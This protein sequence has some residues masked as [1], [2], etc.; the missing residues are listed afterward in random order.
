[1]CPK[2]QKSASCVDNCSNPCQ[3]PLEAASRRDSPPF[4]MSWMRA[5]SVEEPSRATAQMP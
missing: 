1:M 2:V 4:R 5:A 3:P